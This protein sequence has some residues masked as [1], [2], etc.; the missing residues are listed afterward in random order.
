MSKKLV[1]IKVNQQCGTIFDPQAG[2]PQ[3][4]TK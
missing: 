2:R 1:L 4:I 3:Y